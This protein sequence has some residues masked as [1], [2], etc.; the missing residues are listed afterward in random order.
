MERL[1]NADSAI[2]PAWG[3]TAIEIQFWLMTKV[4]ERSFDILA[5]RQHTQQNQAPKSREHESIP[6]EGHYLRRHS[7]GITEF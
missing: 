5:P 4:K 6:N 2:Y 7:F 1:T 3:I